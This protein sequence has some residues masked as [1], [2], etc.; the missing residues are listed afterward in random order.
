MTLAG[1]ST[2][3]LTVSRP[4][5]RNPIGSGT[6]GRTIRC[7]GAANWAFRQWKVKRR[8]PVIGNVRPDRRPR[9]PNPSAAHVP[10]GQSAGSPRS[11]W[12]W[13]RLPAIAYSAVRVRRRVGHPV[14]AGSSLRPIAV[15]GRRAT[16]LPKSDAA[17]RVPPQRGSPMPAQ[18]NGLGN[19]SPPKK[20]P[21]Q[22]GGPN[23]SAVAVISLRSTWRTDGTSAAPLGLEPDRS[24]CRLGLPGRWPGLAWGRPFGTRTPPCIL[25]AVSSNLATE[26]PHVAHTG[27]GPHDCRPC[28]TTVR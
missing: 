10:L 5:S 14:L 20:I 26:I 27:R 1:R 16:A 4:K 9:A 28:P 24:A 22:R 13:S 17:A 21:A 7:T 19:G 15:A 11:I 18:A 25:R 12:P 3:W 23:P 8:R 2:R 6:G